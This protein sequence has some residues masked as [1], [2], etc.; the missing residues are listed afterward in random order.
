MKFHKRW[1][2]IF[3]LALLA[4][5]LQSCLGLGGGGSSTS[6]NFQTKS[7]A[8]GTTIGINQTAQAVFKG[9]IYF[10]LNRNLYVL[11]GTRNVTQ[12][13]HGMDVRR[14]ARWQMDRVY[15]MVQG[16]FRSH[17]DAGQWRRAA[18]AAFGQWHLCE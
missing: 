13:T 10:T 2:I 4:L 8:N 16:L 1:Y 15:Q 9:K 5:S 3:P 18:R 11:D 14:P 7:T 12:L 6:S 17:A